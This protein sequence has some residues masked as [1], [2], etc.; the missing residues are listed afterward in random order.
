MKMIHTENLT[1]EANLRIFAELYEVKD[2]SGQVEKYLKM[3]GLWERRS[4]AAGTFSKS[5]HL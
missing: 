5:L 4:D 3:L 1:N 2:V